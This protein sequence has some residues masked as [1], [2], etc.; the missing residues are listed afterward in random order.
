MVSGGD[1]AGFLGV[2]A[3]AANGLI[4]VFVGLGILEEITGYQRNRLF[5]FREYI[6]LFG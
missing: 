3:R 5:I 6:Q 2:T 4:D 1:V